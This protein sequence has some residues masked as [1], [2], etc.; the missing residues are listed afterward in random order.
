MTPEQIREL[1][2]LLKCDKVLRE[3]LREALDVFSQADTALE[4][5]LRDLSKRVDR[6]EVNDLGDLTNRV[7]KLEDAD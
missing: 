2:G 4:N 1:I 5:D 3:E 6:L 7:A